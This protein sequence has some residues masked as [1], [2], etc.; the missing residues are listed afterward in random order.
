VHLDITYEEVD[1]SVENLW[2]FLFFTGYLK[3]ERDI[4]AL[5]GIKLEM[6]IPN[7]EILY[8]YRRKIIN[9]FDEN[10]K[11]TKHEALLQAF[12][13][14][15]TITL[16][17]ELNNLLMRSISFM[18]TLENFYHGFLVGVLMSFDQYTYAVKS[19]RESGDGRS[20][21]FVY[22]LARSRFAAIIEI[23]I[24]DT[25][26][27]LDKKC[28]EALKQIIDKN[29]DAELAT[30]LFRNEGI[31]HYGIAFCGKRCMVKVGT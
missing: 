23:K 21:I 16:T 10:I 20:D 1:K 28:D 13:S 9:W 17:K 6:S 29:Y 27:K 7:R 2:N 15:D 5:D 11:S 26:E 14:K 19:N 18:D 25:I 8:I 12:L 30:M 4:P 3:K 22:T 24:A 31:V